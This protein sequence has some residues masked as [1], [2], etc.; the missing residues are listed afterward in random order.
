MLLSFRE[1]VFVSQLLSKPDNQ[2]IFFPAQMKNAQAELRT[3][4]A[5]PVS[6]TKLLMQHKKQLHECWIRVF[7]IGDR[8]SLFVLLL[9]SFVAD[10]VYI[11]FPQK[12]TPYKTPL[13]R[14]KGAGQ[15]DRMKMGSGNVPRQGSVRRF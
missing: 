5:P 3:K 1:M 12:A 13:Q 7:A 8:A 14:R 2:C 6:A 11:I 9:F 4:N 10:P 15:Y